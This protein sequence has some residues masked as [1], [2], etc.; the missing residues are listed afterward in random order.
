MR[1]DEVMALLAERQKSHGRFNCTADMAQ[2][3]KRLWHNAIG[4]N[5]LNDIQAEALDSIAVK[6]SRI[7]S[8][9]ANTAE[10]WKDIEGYSRLG[11]S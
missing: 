3:T 10:H 5:N 7:L 1:A 6:V 9:D 2:S 8:G 4:W 11:G